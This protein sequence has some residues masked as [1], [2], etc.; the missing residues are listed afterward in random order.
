MS[1]ENWWSNAQPITKF[2]VM[3][4]LF[5][6][7]VI[8]QNE[9]NVFLMLL[10]W[11]KL[12]PGFQ[13]WR[14][15][16]S[17]FLLGK[18][19]PGFLIKWAM[20]VMFTKYLEDAEFVG[21]TADLIWALLLLILGVLTPLSLLLEFKLMSTSLM[22]A[23]VWIFCRRNSGASISLFVLTIEAKYYPWILMGYHTLMG[24][25]PIAD[26]VGIA[27]GH[28]YVFL[29]DILPKTHKLDLFPATPLWLVRYWPRTSVGVRSFGTAPP[30]RQAEQA[31]PR[32]WGGG[33]ALGRD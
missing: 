25:S 5:L 6:A 23:L 14:L 9:Q 30:Q 19:S 8:A 27:A 28:L 3:A 18:F 4:P 24:G 10:E 26:L 13:L 21:R 1:L 15:L 12:F 11:D 16:T 33:R 7:G 32:Q 29:V 20:F 22:M 17:S 31:A 2:A